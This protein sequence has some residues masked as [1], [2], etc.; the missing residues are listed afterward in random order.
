MIIG[1]VGE[2]LAGKDTVANYLVENHNAMHFRFTHI[3]DA[4]LED[5]NMPISRQN[6]IDLG[7]GLR[8]IFGEH[9]LI[10]AL[11]ARVKRSLASYRVV[12]GIRMDEF[13]IVKSWGAKI[14]YITAPVDIRFQRYNLRREKADDAVMDFEQFKHQDTGP[15]EARIPELGEKADFKI[16]NVGSLPELYKKVD[17]V[18]KILGSKKTNL[19]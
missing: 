5:L 14:I 17:D 16:E 8:K 2:K 7:L 9:V 1:L 4:I 12:N 18:I 10:N 13:D 11:E 19:P 3:L 6:E 15:T